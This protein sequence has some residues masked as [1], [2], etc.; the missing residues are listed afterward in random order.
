MFCFGFT[1]PANATPPAPPLAAGLVITPDVYD[2]RIIPIELGSVFDAAADV[3]VAPPTGR[4]TA[5][6]AGRAASASACAASDASRFCERPLFVRENSGECGDITAAAT[7]FAASTEPAPPLVLSAD[8]VVVEAVVVVVVVVVV[9]DVVEL[10]LAVVAA[11]AAPLL[12]SS[13][14]SS[15]ATSLA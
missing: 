10:V 5:F 3:V 8:V 13:D 4:D 12:P 11:A 9:V 15:S 1:S 7:S 6:A 2:A 14:F